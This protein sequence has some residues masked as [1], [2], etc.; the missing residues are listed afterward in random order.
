MDIFLNGRDRVR[1]YA[2]FEKDNFI[3]VSNPDSNEA[4]VASFYNIHTEMEIWQYENEIIV[5]QGKH[6]PENQFWREKGTLLFNSRR[7]YSVKKGK[8]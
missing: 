8:K 4:I 7:R 5:I 1:V 2:D 6:P 3:D